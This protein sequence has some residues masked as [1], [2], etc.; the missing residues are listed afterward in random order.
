MPNEDDPAE[1]AVWKAAWLR[2]W[3]DGHDR[4]RRSVR[5][6]Q[7]VEAWRVRAAATT[8]ENP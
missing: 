8:S 3:R 7:A 5:A 1:L 4:Y 2:S 6:R